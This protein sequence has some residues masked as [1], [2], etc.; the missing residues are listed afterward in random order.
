FGMGSG[1]T[2]ALQPPGKFFCAQYAIFYRISCVGC[3]REPQSHTHVCSFRHFI[4]RLAA[5]QTIAHYN[6]VSN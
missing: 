6:P 3:I 5:A 1:G 4:C 2:T